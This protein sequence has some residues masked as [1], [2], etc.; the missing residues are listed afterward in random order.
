MG[1]IIG[2]SMRFVIH[3]PI[4]TGRRLIRNAKTMGL[5]EYAYVATALAVG[6]SSL[7]QSARLMK[8]V[9]VA[10]VQEMVKILL[11]GD[12]RGALGRPK[13]VREKADEK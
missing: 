9:T 6:D 2:K 4:A 3:L 13:K 7:E 1:T 10:E 11:A 8:D 5:P 12:A